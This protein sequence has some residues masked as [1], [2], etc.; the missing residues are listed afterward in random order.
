MGKHIVELYGEAE[1]QHLKRKVRGWNIALCSLG[2][3]ALAACIVLT[4]LTRTANAGRMELA[5]II[6]STV[7]GWLVIYFG[8]FA[9]LEGRHE[10]N[11]ADMLGKEERTRIVGTPTVTKQRVVIRHSI[12]ARRVEVQTEG[13]TQCLLVCESRAK[14]LE[15]SGAVALY[16]AHGYVAAYEVVQ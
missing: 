2:L 1:M 12:T 15:N 3:A 6:T 14:A 5:V 11:H 8:I 10:L 16:A 7:A 9:A 13:E 4:A